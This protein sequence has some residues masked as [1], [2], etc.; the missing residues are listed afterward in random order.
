MSI[1]HYLD[2]VFIVSTFLKKQVRILNCE[3]YFYKMTGGKHVKKIRVLLMY[4]CN[5]LLFIMALIMY[6]AIWTKSFLFWSSVRVSHLQQQQYYTK[7]H[8]TACRFGF[9]YTFLSFSK[10]CFVAL[11]IIK[12]SVLQHSHVCCGHVS[13]APWPL[14]CCL[15][16]EVHFTTP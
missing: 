3:L 5:F 14:N 16:K 2:E 10:I 15:A 8:I 12:L 11:I 7:R 1:F 13:I 6:I 9:I 4:C